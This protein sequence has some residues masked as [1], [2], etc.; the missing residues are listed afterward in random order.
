MGLDIWALLGVATKFTLYLGVLVACGAV[1]FRLVFR[2]ILFRAADWGEHVASTSV[3]PTLLWFS[4]I[5]VIASVLSFFVGAVIVT[6][7]VSGMGNTEI[8]GQLWDGPVGGAFSFRISG[9]ALMIASLLFPR[10]GRFLALLGVA[11]VLWSF[12]KVGHA[13]RFEFPWLEVILSLHLACV[14]F[15]IGILLPLYRLAGDPAHLSDA[16]DLAHRFGQIASVVVPVLMLS[17]FIFAWNL[18]GSFSILLGA[19]YGGTLIGKTVIVGGLLWLAAMNKT[20]HV[21]ALLRGEMQAAQQLRR[22]I[23]FEW[24]AIVTILMITAVLTS[25]LIVPK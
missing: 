25:L 6:G 9:L 14:A 21:P 5:G 20:R 12:G 15:W 24:T 1:L 17:G 3:R 19:F 22:T 23:L 7:D 2:D 18:L 10:G 8:L 16:A 4:L 11:L 13:T